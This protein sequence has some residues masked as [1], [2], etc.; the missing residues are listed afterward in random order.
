M[1]ESRRRALYVENINRDCIY[2]YLD[3][4]LI[5]AHSGQLQILQNICN[6]LLGKRRGILLDEHRLMQ[7]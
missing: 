3:L 6:G 5:I 4:I 1:R 2:L 7:T